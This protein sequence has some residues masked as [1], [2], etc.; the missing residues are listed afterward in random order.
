M[1]FENL[2]DQNGYR[3]GTMQQIKKQNIDVNGRQ[4]VHNNYN[5]TLF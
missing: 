2:D 3:K 4:N 1:L 5:F